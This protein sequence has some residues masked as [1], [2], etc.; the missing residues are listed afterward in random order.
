M[1][2]AGKGKL[3]QELIYAAPK[4]EKLIKEKYPQAAITDV[5]DYIHTERFEVEIEGVS[6]EEFYSF[7]RKSGF[8]RA[9]FGFML[10]RG[11][12][13]LEHD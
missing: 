6:S 5:S 12:K 2:K 8:I 1:S 10:G 4:V 11:L 9:C 3:L 13:R 7:A